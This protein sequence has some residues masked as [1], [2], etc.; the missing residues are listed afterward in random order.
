MLRRNSEAAS[1]ATREGSTNDSVACLALGLVG[2]A[3]WLSVVLGA[4]V[5]ALGLYDDMVIRSVIVVLGI[6]CAC[7]LIDSGPGMGGLAI[8]KSLT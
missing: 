8:Y 6:C 5:L 7:E 1:D 4:F 2:S 3:D